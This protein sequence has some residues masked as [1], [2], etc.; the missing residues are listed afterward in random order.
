[1]N[2][3]KKT[4]FVTLAIAT[5]AAAIAG[6]A[7]AQSYGYGQ[8]DQGRHEQG[9]R[10]EQNSR[11]EHESRYEQT[12]R[13]RDNRRWDDRADVN[14]RQAQ[15]ERR[16]EWGVRRGALDRREADRLRWEVRDIARL[17][18]QYRHGGLTQPERRGLDRRLDR[19]EAQLERESHDRDYGYG[20][21]RDDRR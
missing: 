17:E 13:P 9:D 12:N 10:Y 16:I 7:A 4:L 20:Y 5:A 1:M 11:Y 14:A 21:G 15:I 19:L 8:R 18:A 3:V 6:P 2:T